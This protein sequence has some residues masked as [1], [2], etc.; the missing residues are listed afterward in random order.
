MSESSSANR[1]S[2]SDPFAGRRLFTVEEANAALPLVRAIASDLAALSRDVI[3]RRERLAALRGGRQRAARDVYS[4]ELA[5]VEEDI[6]RDS[7]R[8]LEYV[9][10]LRELGVEPKSGPEGLVDFPS[11]REGRPVYLCWKLGEPTVA[12]WHDVDAGFMGRQ[13]V[14]T[15]ASGPALPDSSSG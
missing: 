5:Q 15:A 6:Q 10:E 4:Q 7:E 3:D 14:A 11:Q 9:E 13:P 8:L 2:P 1:L 12:H